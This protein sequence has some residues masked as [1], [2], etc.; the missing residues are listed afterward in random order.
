MIAIRAL[1]GTE[2]VVN[3]DAVTLIVG[4]YRT[5]SARTPMC[6]ALIAGCW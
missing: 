4:P 2:V 6:T 5:I 3:Q 1:D